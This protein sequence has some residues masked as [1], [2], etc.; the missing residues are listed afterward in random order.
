MPLPRH[1]D[2]IVLGP[3]IVYNDER[4][5][6]EDKIEKCSINLSRLL[7]RGSGRFGEHISLL[8]DKK[9]RAYVI[10][11]NAGIVCPDANVTYVLSLVCRSMSSRTVFV[12]QDERNLMIFLR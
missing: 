11:S 7:M 2:C 10:P 12:V 8:I 5:E 3:S 6:L 1:L 9:W 4:V